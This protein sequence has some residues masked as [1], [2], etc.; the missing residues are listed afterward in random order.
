M[1]NDDKPIGQ[2]LSRREALTLFGLSGAALLAACAPEAVQQA[3]ATSTAAATS[4]TAATGAPATAASL[5]A[6]IARPELTE[7]PYFVD[8]RLERA[9]IRSDP[10]DGSVRAGVPL[11]LTFLVSTVKDN[12]C[13]PLSGAMVDIWHCDAQGVYSDASDPNFGSTAGQKFLR[14]YQVTDANGLARFTTIYPG[15]YQGRAV[16][17]H[18]KIRNY[19][20]ADSGFDFTS[21]VFFED[22]L[23]E[24][25]YASQTDYAKAG[26]FLRNSQDGIYGQS[27]GQTLLTLTPQ[28]EGYSTTFDIGLTM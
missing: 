14:G 18:F 19:P 12:A 10:S 7:G 15:W 24:Q 20:P 27:G 2:I 6:C 11:A 13:Q 23:S 26:S 3:L 22:S 1:D 28:A 5:P 17:I 16:H 9:D 21:Q 4:T 25:I 8:E